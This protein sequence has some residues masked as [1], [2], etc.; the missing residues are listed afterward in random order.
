[1]ADHNALRDAERLLAEAVDLLSRIE[2]EIQ[3][4]T[5]ACADGEADLERLDRLASEAAEH[6]AWLGGA[7]DDGR[8]WQGGLTESLRTV[9]NAAAE[10]GEVRIGTWLEAPA[11]GA[12]AHSGGEEGLQSRA[13]LPQPQQLRTSAVQQA[14]TRSRQVAAERWDSL[15]EDMPSFEDSYRAALDLLAD[16]DQQAART[17]ERQAPRR[18]RE[19]ADK[20]RSTKVRS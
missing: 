16:A 17:A 11:L 1:M 14:A 9:A 18:R 2:R 13:V 12:V 6:V 15:A 10:L 4:L 5:D 7:L 20:S 19:R 3:L 8:R